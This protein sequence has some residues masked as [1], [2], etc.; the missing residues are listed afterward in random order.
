M[1]PSNFHVAQFGGMNDWIH[2]GLLDA[3]SAVLLR[4]AEIADGK[5]S[6]VRMPQKINFTPSQL[7]HYGTSDRSVVKW[8][9]RYYW[10]DNT[11]AEPP[12][13]GGN[14]E[15]LGVPYPLSQPTITGEAPGEG[16]TGLTGKY[17]YCICYVNENG[18]EGAPGSLTDYEVVVELSGEWGKVIPGETFPD[19]I[20]YAKIYRTVAEGAT[21]YCVGELYPDDKYFLDK[22]ADDDALVLEVLSSEDNY[23][24]PDGGKYLSESGGVFFLAVGSKLYFSRQGNPHA[25]PVLN[26][27]GI[28]DDVTGITPEFQGVLVF[29]RNN[30]FRV[31]GADDPATIVKS[32]I[33]GNQGCVTYCS[34]A[35]ISNAPVWLS[36][37][38]ICLWD[39]EN[40]QVVSFQVL[41]TANL[42]VKY[43]CAANDVYYLFLLNGA[44]VFDR[45]NGDVFRKLSFS[46]DY[47]WYDANNDRMF[48]QR[49]EEVLLYGASAG[50][51]Y[52]YKSP[53]IGGSIAVTKKYSVALIECSGAAT[54][55]V[56]LDG[57]DHFKVQLPRG[58]RERIKFPHGSIGRYAQIS[59]A[60]AGSLNELAVLYE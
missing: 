4:D 40:I 58:G 7:G 15:P 32:L 45:R 12:Y 27:I 17:K 3:K 31:V 49:G 57:K 43:A 9:D 5:I 37:D 1:M 19:G 39:G 20:D 14:V 59:V 24:P 54:M 46:C 23:P 6:A 38:G 16:E 51:R 18:W 44:I 30:A 13:Y 53:Y 33:P 26:Y 47:A 29:T 60:G 34:I 25:W 11:A 56:A 35:N 21:F 2:P 52:E 42:Q 22:T 55:S 8:Y 10:S 50:G 41:K 48:L 36:N 28:D